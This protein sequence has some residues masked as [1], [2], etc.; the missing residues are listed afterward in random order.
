MAP[1]WAERTWLTGMVIRLRLDGV[2]PREVLG[3]RPG[4]VGGGFVSH[5]QLLSL[6]YHKR[7]EVGRGEERGHKRRP[8]K[9]ADDDECS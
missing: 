5:R 6:D 4:L 9:Q 2:A 8:A 1:R 3:V 7:K